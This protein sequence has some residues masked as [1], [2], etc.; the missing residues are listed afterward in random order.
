MSAHRT[1]LALAL[2]CLGLAACDDSPTALDNLV[3]LPGGSALVFE[4]AAATM[5]ERSRIEEIVAATTDAARDLIDIDGM[6]VVIRQSTAFIIPQFGFGGLASSGVVTIPIDPSSSAWPGSM[7]VELAR[8]L[9]HEFHHVAR[10][11]ARGANGTLFEAIV[12]EGLADRFI[13]ELLAG[14]PPIWATAVQGAEL[15]TWIETASETW[16]EPE[17]DP[18]PWFL[19]EFESEV[20]QWTGYSIGWE[21]TGRYLEAN[22]S[23]SASTLVGTPASAFLP[24]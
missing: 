11:R 10:F 23:Q 24:E 3:V 9:A 18:R 19:P 16:M 6:T 22:P 21:L 5:A 13:I 1:A 2:A 20:P 15:E 8:V 12:T 17:F 7:E 4:G 14:D